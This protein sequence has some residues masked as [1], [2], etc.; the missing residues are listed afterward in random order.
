MTNIEAESN[1]ATPS[2]YDRALAAV[3]AGDL[4]AAEALFQDSLRESAHFKTYER[5]G[6]L[7]RRR[8]DLVGATLYFAAAVGLGVNQP[9]PRLL[10]AE[11]LVERG[12]I[13]SAAMKLSEAL[14]LNPQYKT[15]AEALARLRAAYPFL[16]LQLAPTVPDDS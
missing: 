7:A 10:L 8:G 13:Y 2:I 12:E 5:L 11:V 14:R 6:E 15:A 4:A 1:D 9:R 3:Q 16:E